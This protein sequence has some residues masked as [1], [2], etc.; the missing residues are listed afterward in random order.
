MGFS[1][2]SP[3][4]MYQ[5]PSGYIFRIRIPN[6]LKAV[7]GKGEFRYSLRTGIS[8]IAK[9][10]ANSIAAYLRQLFMDVRINVALFTKEKIQNL[11]KEYI[12]K[13]LANDECRRF[14]HAKIPDT[15]TANKE[16][17]SEADEI[18]M[19]VDQ[20]NNS[21]GDFD[22]NSLLRNGRVQDILRKVKIFLGGVAGCNEL[23]EKGL[24]LSSPKE[25][26]QAVQGLSGSLKSGKNSVFTTVQKSYI[27]EVEKGS[28][29]TEK[30]KAENLSIFALFMRVV[31]DLPVEQ[32]D[33][34]VMTEYK[35][36]LM[37]L[38]P[39]LNKGSKYEGKTVAEIIGTQP[40]KTITAN[41]INK[42][43]RRLSGLFNYAVRNGYMQSNPAEGLQ[44]KRQ[45]RADQERQE[46]TGEDLQNLFGSQ[47]YMEGKHRHSY[48]YWTPLIALYSGCR[49]EEICQLHLEDIRQEQGVWVFDIN[50]KGEKR[51][52]NRSSE[53]LIPIHPHLVELG[54][55]EH[56]NS[57]VDK[58]EG[59]L[60]PELQK[61]RD[62]YGQTVSKWFQR[63]KKRCGIKGCKTFHSFRHTFITHLKHKQVDPYMIHEIDGHAVDSETMGRYGKRYTPAILLENAISLINYDIN[64]HMLTR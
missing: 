25:P 39:N 23:V 7:V 4:Y 41:T 30:T 28:N 1:V 19:Q 10:R 29:W 40:E 58:G 17:A 32:V 9:H 13:I 57:L 56:V 18:M 14:Q 53:R 37:Q 63:Y 21:M 62:G 6:D 36:T 52:K 54:I 42:Y 8:R 60:F 16:V 59:R 15:K 2:S 61:R 34:K 51:L 26:R 33:R 35:S 22:S 49:L 64:V 20:L 27:L 24:N 55:L 48:A 46:Y 5:S 43:I 38:P 12:C 3:T 11:A 44:I 31:G 50:D 47:E 45:K